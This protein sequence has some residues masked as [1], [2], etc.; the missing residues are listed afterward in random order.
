MGLLTEH[1]YSLLKVV[2]TR[3]PPTGEPTRLVKLRNPWGKLEWRGE[4]SDSSPLWSP[5]LRDELDDGRT[6]GDDGT[7]WMSFEG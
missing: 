6:P 3:H 5:A 1:A 2:G 4:W 7:S